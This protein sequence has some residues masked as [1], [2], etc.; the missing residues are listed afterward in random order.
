VNTCRGGYF[1]APVLANLVL[2][3]IVSR[4]L[5]KTHH[6]LAHRTDEESRKHAARSPDIPHPSGILS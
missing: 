1:D 2:G 4:S 6:A 3:R 5:V